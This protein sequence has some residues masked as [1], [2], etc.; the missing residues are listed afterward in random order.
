MPN[1][2]PTIIT[3]PNPPKPLSSS[4]RVLPPRLPPQTDQVSTRDESGIYFSFLKR[5]KSVLV[6]LLYQYDFKSIIICTV[7]EQSQWYT[8]LEI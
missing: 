4:R 1:A 6:L 8:S 7:L 2:V 5:H 3:A